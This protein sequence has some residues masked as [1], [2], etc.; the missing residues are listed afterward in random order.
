MFIFVYLLI[1]TYALTFYFNFKAEKKI[2]KNVFLNSLL[3]AVIVLSVLY[4]TFLNSH[5]S[6][7]VF[8]FLLIL[9]MAA[10]Y[11]RMFHTELQYDNYDIVLEPM[12]NTFMLQIRTTILFLIGMTIFKFLPLTQAILYSALIVIGG[13][14]LY[15]LTQVVRNLIGKKFQIKWSL[16]GF[17]EIAVPFLI[18]FFIVAIMV[19]FNLPWNRLNNNLNLNPYKPSYTYLQLEPY[20]LDYHYDIT[21]KTNDKVNLTDN[22]VF[23]NN[24]TLYTSENVENFIIFYN[25]TN[26]DIYYAYYHVDDM[27]T[28]Y[29]RVRNGQDERIHTIETEAYTHGLVIEDKIYLTSGKYEYNG[30]IY[31]YD[32]DMI[33]TEEIKILPKINMFDPQNDKT[34]LLD[35]MTVK[36]DIINLFYTQNNDEEDPT[37]YSISIEYRDTVIDA[38]FYQS[39]SFFHIYMI[40][41]LLFI[42]IS[43]YRKNIT[44]IEFDKQ[45]KKERA[46]G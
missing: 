26:D 40:G 3:D 30:N 6:L 27:N 25:E 11:T 33:F 12:K 16:N 10:I 45:I 5:I 35:G 34:F 28:Y 18:V 7:I 43:N 31:V 44:V 13:F 41:L 2:E 8:W 23:G 22:I 29:H 4:L 15:Y 36:N 46:F 20:E 9:T 42:R 17:Q 38:S 14:G 19:V 1:S 39:F 24:S 37:Y 32:L 21:Y